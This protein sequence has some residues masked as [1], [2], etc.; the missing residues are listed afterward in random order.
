MCTYTTNAKN[1]FSSLMYI[2]Y[3]Y[4]VSF[5]ARI[6]THMYESLCIH[7]CVCLVETCAD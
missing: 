3:I 5:N 2:I 7:V 6:Y 1:P 4:I